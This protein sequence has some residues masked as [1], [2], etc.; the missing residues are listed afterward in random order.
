[1]LIAKVMHVSMFV[2]VCMCVHTYNLPSIYIYFAPEETAKSPFAR[3][4]T[5]AAK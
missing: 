1:M 2:C 3:P 4:V 5:S